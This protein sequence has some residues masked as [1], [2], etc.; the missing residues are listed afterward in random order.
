MIL[1]LLLLGVSIYLF[2]LTP[3][4]QNWLT[5]R[6][7]QY[8]SKQWQ[9]RIELKNARFSLFD[10]IQLESLTVY[11]SKADTL[12]YAGSLELRI[13]NW[14][15][16]RSQN[17]LGPIHLKHAFVQLQRT[18]SVWQHQA[19]FS[20][21]TGSGK[22]SSGT[23][24]HFN[25]RD[26]QFEDVAF[27]LRDG[28]SGRD[29]LA[30]F[31][32]VEL[33]A[34]LLDP[35][36]SIFDIQRLLIE[37]PEIEIVDYPGLQPQ[38][39]ASPPTDPFRITSWPV[40]PNLHLTDFN[41]N[42]GRFSWTKKGQ[43]YL[44][45]R[46]TSSNMQWTALH[47]SLHE[48]R[49]KN[50][51]LQIPLQSS[52][53]ESGGLELQQVSA[54]LN[55]SADGLLV[56]NL[57]V[58]TPRSLLQQNISWHR[59]GHG[60]TFHI[61][62]DDNRIDPADLIFFLHQPLPFSDPILMR[63][64]IDLDGE[65]I[66][67][68]N[69]WA[70]WGD[71]ARVS[72]EVQ[73]DRW[74]DPKNWQIEL[75]HS[76]L[77]ARSDF[78]NRF[79]RLAP[80][81]S[82]W[83]NRIGYAQVR[84][85]GSMNAQRA[86][87]DGT[88]RTQ[89]GTL[90]VLGAVAYGGKQEPVYQAAISGQLDGLMVLFPGSDIKSARLQTE[91]KGV[92]IKKLSALGEIRNLSTATYQYEPIRFSLEGSDPKWEVQLYAQD[93][94]LSGIIHLTGE[95]FTRQPR[96]SI[97]TRIDRMDLTRL[98]W[99]P[100]GLKLSGSLRGQFTGITPSTIQGELQGHSLELTRNDV[101]LS[102]Q[103]FDLQI[104][105]QNDLHDL[106]FRS[107]ELDAELRGRFDWNALPNLAMQLGHRYFPAWIKPASARQQNDSI[108]FRVRA[109]NIEDYLELLHA[110]MRGLSNASFQG[111][112]LA[113][114]GFSAFDAS[115]PKLR[116]GGTI[117]HQT[118]L[119]FVGDPD[120]LHL[121]AQVQRIQWNDS[122]SIP[123][124]KIELDARR[125]TANIRLMAG[126]SET[127]DK[128][129]IRS[130]LI[131]YSDGLQLDLSP[132]TFLIQGKLWHIDEDG[133]LVIR[134][135]RPTYGKISFREGDQRIDLRT[136]PSTSG[137]NNDIE[138]ALQSLNLHDLAPFFLP[139]NELEGLLSG[140][141]RIQDPA[142]NLRIEADTLQT[143]L[144]RFGS[145]SIGELG[146]SLA[147]DQS[148]KRLTAAG[149][150]LGSNDKLKFNARIELAGPVD[151]NRIHLQAQSYPIKI[152]ERFIGHLFSDIQG[153]LTGDVE[154][155]GDLNNPSLYGSGRLSG[156]GMRI[157]YTNCFYSIQDANI[158][159]TP[160][161]IDLDG[162]V[163]K[164][165]ATGNPIYVNGGIAHKSFRQMYY[166]LSFT[167]R[168]RSTNADRPVLLLN[169]SRSQ[170][171]VYYGVARGTTNLQLRGPQSDLLLSMQAKSSDRDSSY[172][173]LL[174]EQGRES[175]NADFLIE[176]EY[177]R[178]ITGADNLGGSD[179]LTV[180]LEISATPLVN[181]R[182]VLD[183]LTGDVIRGRGNGTL[184]LRSGTNEPLTLRGRYN[185]EE[186]NYL[187]TF[188]SFFKKPFEI[189]KGG[190]H[191]VEWSGD[192]YDANIHLEANYKAEK[193][194]FAPLASSLNLGSDIKNARG[195][196]FVVAQLNGKLFKPNITFSLAFPP[197]SVVD[198]NQ[199]LSML[200]NQLQKNPNELNRQ[201]TYLIVFN[202]FAPSELAGDPSGPGI[203][204]S[205]ISGVLLNVL[206]DQINKLLG[207]LL[208]SDKYTINLNTSLYNRD[209][210]SAGNNALN[211]GSNI[212]F[213][214]GRSFFNNRF[215]ISGGLGF[216]APIGQSTTNTNLSQSIQ[217]LPDVTM[218][219][220]LN[221]SG[222]LRVGFF[223]RKSNDFLS[224]NAGSITGR[225]AGGSLSYQKEYDRLGDLFKGLFRSKKKKPAKNQEP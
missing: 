163:L 165:S 2:L 161:L 8:L 125:D 112:Y 27:R 30:R 4:G 133:Q 203:G 208:K 49:R 6:V 55:W 156:A 150:T 177:G 155:T 26:L 43:R 130:R 113:E 35:A 94:N 128:A 185:I 196:V 141:I 210:M 187:F 134:K 101:P 96:W 182:V 70:Q 13:S 89:L 129:D 5:Q 72:G 180:D 123:E 186:G 110:P 23:G 116:W 77:F 47:V 211:L 81:A 132:S 181:A 224:N 212:N 144:L 63:G 12:L 19:L 9:T 92:G 168:S 59:Q 138:V 152:L 146:T 221:P 104:N 84:G 78:A 41:L 193:V 190:Q 21:F 194:S 166:D 216:D 93:P 73:I 33:K 207:N 14:F 86:S 56:E 15:F 121:D 68:K 40:P 200:V 18:D 184:K 220:L 171:E 147:Y 223:Y 48:V 131:A 214:I 22:S 115:I 215:I 137:T 151:S 107:N 67:A 173:T 71:A 167:T 76:E 118:E 191:Y 201:V 206:S 98:G 126:F 11:D 85:K 175:G 37:K 153:K 202:S 16:L 140:R 54:L 90:Q 183:E 213:S 66:S 17:D 62:L 189:R 135:D 124:A 192:P 172:I 188:Q 58:Q 20:Q 145:D 120:S 80:D 198:R 174:S 3:F 143:R 109:Y 42:D 36:D 39:P 148:T 164:D 158:E 25:F 69:L 127:V 99:N 83:V 82:A 139:N 57:H 162:W 218:E 52:G 74:Q 32:T 31:E 179:N 219:W 149:Q 51:T 44:P 100:D 50:G 46:L 136:I 1:G 205:T 102:L 106:R 157:N 60:S 108:S 28:W 34:K 170:N 122:I 222:S 159:I 225:R 178:E 61:Q 154:L 24:T 97:D 29:I 103:E 75:S 204:V 217:L 10:N 87:W 53:R 199:E 119:K 79:L 7:L 209:W 114:T 195:D 91:I 88:L 45:G 64:T 117:F 169:T 65:K 197:N 142:G 95:P 38:R 111:T 176:R 105:Q 160:N